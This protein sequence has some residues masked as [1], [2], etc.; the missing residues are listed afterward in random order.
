MDLLK[1]VLIDDEPLA[2]DYLEHLLNKIA[3]YEIVGKYT[4]PIEAKKAL[5]EMKVDVVF[6]DI[7]MPGLNGIELAEKITEMN[8]NSSIVFVTAFD[9]FAIKA[10]ELN[11]LDYLLKPIQFERIQSTTKRLKKQMDLLKNHRQT[12]EES[13]HIQLFRDPSIVRDGRAVSLKWRT[14]KA[15]QLF[16]YLIHHRDRMVS[17]SELIELL[18]PDFIIE[19][20]QTQ[21]YS[22]VYQV[23]KTIKIFKEKI[24]ILSE[25]NGYRIALKDVKVDV[26]Q[27]EQ[28][29]RLNESVCEENIEEYERALTFFTGEYFQGYDFIWADNDQFR[30]RMLWLTSKMKV[31]DWYRQNKQLDEAL[32]HAFEIYQRYP[33]E[34]EGYFE[35]MKTYAADGK[36]MLVN[37]YY[38]ELTNM[39]E[40]ELDVGLS[41]KV[42]D[43]YESQIGSLNK[44]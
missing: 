44:K 21:L 23:R 19:K 34:E 22:T 4:N 20:A 40:E 42:I 13:L 1:A 8:P 37:Q 10:F 38:H 3:E 28:L 43:W 7:E 26:D 39:L 30:M 5:T 17:K 33:M 16:F 41:E 9:H 12:E 24:S 11:S 18:W 14:S 25:G 32:K 31:I 36:T 29:L 35:L 6:L 15:Q 27:F 2:L